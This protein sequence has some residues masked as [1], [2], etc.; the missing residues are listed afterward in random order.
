MDCRD[1]Q[2]YSSAYID[3]MLSKK[4]ELDFK[5]HIK[6]CVTCSIAFENLKTVVECVN[7]VES[8]ELPSNFSN[9]LHEKL[10]GTKTMDET[11]FTWW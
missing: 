8:V 1:I 10:Q 9:E 3:N 6:K 7:M 11:D 2:I 5:N 4:E